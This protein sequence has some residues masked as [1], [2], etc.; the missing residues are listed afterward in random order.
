ML[1][2]S[3]E[4]KKEKKIKKT[5]KVSVTVLCQTLSRPMHGLPRPPGNLGSP[6]FSSWE[7]HLQPLLLPMQQN[8]NY[9]GG[10]GR[11]SMGEERLWLAVLV[12]V[13]LALWFCM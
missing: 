13:P 7:Y 6:V 11:E 10:G 2:A 1:E 3:S 12:I 5:N 8:S 9:I 4:K